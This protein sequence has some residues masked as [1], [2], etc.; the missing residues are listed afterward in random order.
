MDRTV[1]IWDFHTGYLHSTLKEHTDVVNWCCFSHDSKL[2]ASSSNDLTIKIWNTGTEELL[3]VIGGDKDFISFCMFTND[4]KGILCTSLNFI[5]MFSVADGTLLWHIETPS[6]VLSLALSPNQKY[7][8][9]AHNDMSARLIDLKDKQFVNSYNGH[10]SWLN[11]VSFSPDGNSIVTSSQ[12][13]FCKVWNVD[14]GSNSLEVLTDIFD[15]AFIGDNEFVIVAATRTNEI[16]LLQSHD[17]ICNS[18][19][20]PSKITCCVLS[21]DSKLSAIGFDDGTIKVLETISMNV[22]STLI[23]HSAGITMMKF[24]SRR[25]VSSSVD[26]TCVLWCLHQNAVLCVFN[27]HKD[28]ITS[29]MFVANGDMVISSSYDGS[30]V[31]WDSQCGDTMFTFNHDDNAVISCEVSNNGKHFLSCSADSKARLWN[32]S[33]GTL[34]HTVDDHNDA[35]RC[36]AFSNDDS[37]FATGSD[38]GTVKVWSVDNGELVCECEGHDGW[39]LDIK[40]N[41]F[42]DII[43]TLSNDI[44]WFNL[45][46][47]ILQTFHIIGN[48]LRSI[49]C[50]KDFKKCI[51]IDNLGY[52]Y[53]LDCIS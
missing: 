35:V 16:R 48:S 51:T 1:M 20:F 8:A 17:N 32:S 31:V 42:N 49:S 45:D 52:S 22:N 19:K 11:S 27:G 37:V 21:D 36:V 40:F 47:D 4:G 25:L 38:D 12:D 33:D 10:D 44:K 28:V 29:C 46:G 41:E 39:V 18:D 24:N 26:N 3:S 34:K 30:M 43:L 23:K 53:I 7:L 14:Y 2:V 9:A 13:G 6:D 5:Q 50:S 15:A